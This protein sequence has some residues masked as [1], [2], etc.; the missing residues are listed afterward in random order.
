MV[1]YF[2]GGCVFG[3]TTAKLNNR[4]NVNYFIMRNNVENVN[5]FPTNN[6]NKKKNKTY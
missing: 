4:H 3:K 6:N 1:P 5:Y 2:R